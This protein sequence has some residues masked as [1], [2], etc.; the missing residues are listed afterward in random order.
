[1]CVDMYACID[2]GV[3]SPTRISE[4]QKNLNLTTAKASFLPKLG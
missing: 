3:A 4:V 2:A 1:M